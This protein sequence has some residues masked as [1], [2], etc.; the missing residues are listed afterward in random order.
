MQT[1]HQHAKILYL[2]TKGNWGGAQR[3]VYELATHLPP[4]QM[5]LVVMGTGDVLERK[6]AARGIRTLR[7]PTLQRNINPVRDLRAF[8]EIMRVIRTERPRVIHLNS[9]KAG[10]LGALAGRIAG[11]PRIVFTAHGWS[12]NEPR[13]PLQK[14][15][16]AALQ[17]LT[18]LLAHVTIGVSLH[19]AAQMSR[20]PF[21]KRKIVVI[22]HGRAPFAI[23]PRHA[24]H[25]RLFRTPETPRRII[26]TIAELR[27]N[28]GIDLLLLAS[29]PLLSPNVHLLIVGEGDEREE[30]AHYAH[31]L[32]IE[33]FVTFTG[34]VDEAADHLS[35]F[36]IFVLPSRTE[37]F[38]YVILEAA[39]AKLPVIASR[40]GG[41]PELIRHEETGLLFPARDTEQLSEL[42]KMLLDDSKKR[43]TLGEALHRSLQQHL[44]ITEMLAR[45]Y[46]LYRLSA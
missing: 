5:P 3:Y 33:Q 24:S 9:A 30:L 7:I 1:P 12:F 37:S 16:I 4:G 2:I 36:D 27:R 42:L 6:L 32:G 17:W 44:S 22:P 35:A 21:T 41:I 10:G 19:V 8:F 23:L 29:A 31:H 45:T 11:V 38:G 20:L 15:F 39:H 43:K 25:A 26:G 18:V 40:V 34:A 46:A 28:K 13:P 14:I